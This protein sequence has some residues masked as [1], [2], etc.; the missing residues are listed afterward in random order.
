M[1]D[2][3]PADEGYELDAIPLRKA[4]FPMGDT[5]DEL[6]VDLNGDNLGTQAQR[7]KQGQNS[8]VCG[9]FTHIAIHRQLHASMS[10]ASSGSA[11]GAPP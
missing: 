1:R 11:E 4:S 3:S 7:F 8:R 2:L 5:G 6:A 10:S 9:R